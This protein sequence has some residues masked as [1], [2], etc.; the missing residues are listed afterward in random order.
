MKFQVVKKA[1]VDDDIVEQILSEYTDWIDERGL[2]L[3]GDK[4]QY[5]RDLVRSFIEDRNSIVR[6]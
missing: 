2:L 6:G 1:D 5:N 4:I 3:E